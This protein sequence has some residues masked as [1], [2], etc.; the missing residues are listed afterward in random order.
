[1][2]DQSK[3]LWLLETPRKI[4]VFFSPDD[5][6]PFHLLTVLSGHHSEVGQSFVIKPGGVF[7]KA[8]YSSGLMSMMLG[9]DWVVRDDELGAFMTNLAI[10]GDE[11]DSLIFNNRIVE[12]GRE[13][14]NDK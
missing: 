5:L 9:K 2:Q 12:R 7:P 14:L 10:H 6:S 4:K 3:P 1:V 11:K 8:S 13:L